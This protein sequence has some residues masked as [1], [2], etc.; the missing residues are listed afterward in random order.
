MYIENYQTY[1]VLLG[2]FINVHRQP[3]RN[4]SRNNSMD[5]NKHVPTR[6]DYERT[7]NLILTRPVINLCTAETKDCANVSGWKWRTLSRLHNTYMCSDFEFRNFSKDI[8]MQSWVARTK[9]SRPTPIASF[10]VLPLK[11]NQVFIT[12]DD[13]WHTNK[14]KI[15]FVFPIAL[16]KVKVWRMHLPN[17]IYGI[18]FGFD[19]FTRL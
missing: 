14:Q 18:V 15:F 7:E 17:L 16:I 3:R 6:Y 12:R 9:R 8:E 13:W 19:P 10:V 5:P 4:I 2:K 11:V 1:Y